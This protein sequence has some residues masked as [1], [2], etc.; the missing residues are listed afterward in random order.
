MHEIMPT[1]SHKAVEQG[2]PHGAPSVWQLTYGPRRPS[3]MAAQD[4][5]PCLPQEGVGEGSRDRVGKFDTQADQRE[6]Q[7]TARFRMTKG[8]RR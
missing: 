5:T 2:M 4:G 7:Y 6:Q 8:R 3:A 1:I